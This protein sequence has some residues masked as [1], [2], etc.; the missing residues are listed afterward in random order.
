M[1]FGFNKSIQT[2]IAG[3]A[4]MA[5]LVSSGILVSLALVSAKNTQNVVSD[6]V[7]SLVDQNT[8][9]SLKNL[10]G[11]QAGK[12]QAKFDVALD[13]A[14]TMAHTFVLTKEPGS[15]VQLGR[16]QINSILLNVLKN[17]PEFNGT[18]SCWEP[19]AL[20]GRDSAFQTGKNGNNDKT[21]RFTPYWNR[22]DKG[23]IAVQPLV[24]YDTMDRH[25]NGVL[26]GGWYIGPRTTNTESV[27]DP[28]PYIVQGKQVWLTT[29][30]V[31]I[32]VSGKFQGVAG[33]D[34]NLD[35][36][37]KLAAEAN[38]S[39]FG[40]KGGVT[41]VSHMGLVVADS[42]KPALIGQSFKDIAGE[43]WE[44]RLADIQAGRS[45]VSVDDKT[46]MMLAFS[47]IPL[48][49]TGKPWA[50]MVKVPT[51]V[52]LA[53]ARALD[54]DLSARA[55]AAT[56][57]QLGVAIAV[58]LVGILFLWVAAGRIAKPIREAA[59]VANALAEG[60]LT[61]KVDSSAKD[62]VGELMSSLGHMVDRLSQTIHDVN[63]AAANIASSSKEVAT[64]AQDMS[65]ASSEQAASV[66]ETSASIEQ[67]SASINQNTDNAKVTDGMASQA[68]KQAVEGG[69]A[70]KETVA[71]MKQIAGKIGIIDDI[72]YQTNLL[73]LNAAIEAAR[74]GEHGKGF[75][76]VA[77]E[78]RKLAERS[79]IAAQEISE[80]ASGSVD[81]AESAGQLLDT[82]VPAI[83]KT[84]ELVQEIAAASSEQSSGAGQ[85]NTAMSQ[86]NQLTQRNA[87][88]SEE[89]AA[90]AEEMSSQ[91]AQLQEVMSFFKVDGRLG[92]EHAATHQAKTSAKSARPLQLV[93]K[94][95]SQ[96]G[97]VDE[98]GFV[99]F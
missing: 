72:A 4:G 34:Y 2:K 63:G 18:Y 60:D 80:L 5:L 3:I 78:V 29:L 88:A 69:V 91:A 15:G 75:A 52:V 90:T 1:Q 28:F 89:L 7:S 92:Q 64:T 51:D 86:L 31:P 84:S 44:A 42:E 77:A 26:K 83:G 35:F 76:V 56:L 6:R 67:M 58:A 30:S 87:G 93:N 39:L 20:D 50:V 65:Q 27:L 37:Q 66:E 36:V 47:P 8:R 82:M 85:I 25:P 10:T 46:G 57:W 11:D 73:A 45:S 16:D 53:E 33:T 96:T 61:V 62:E 71:A 19:D 99:R 38:K 21:G 49:R 95:L 43:G 22:D 74:A 40:G 54:R 24:E 98:T 55:N 13:A 81:K 68:A 97:A 23:N 94:A 12:I 9:D 48:G 32:Q 17:N 14:R 79:Q 41:I 59:L 70:V